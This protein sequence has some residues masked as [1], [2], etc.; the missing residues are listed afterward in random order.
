MIFEGP[1]KRFELT[2]DGYEFPELV[3]EMHDANWLEVT[4]NVELP[5]GSYTASSPC[6]LT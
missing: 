5:D 6:F 1:G 4:V 2:L 3:D